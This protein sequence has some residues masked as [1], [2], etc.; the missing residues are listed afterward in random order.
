MVENETYGQI[1]HRMQDEPFMLKIKYTGL[2]MVLYPVAEA[3]FSY[4]YELLI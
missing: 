2:G 3:L 4:L 1:L